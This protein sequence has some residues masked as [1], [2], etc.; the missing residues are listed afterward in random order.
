DTTTRLWVGGDGS[1]RIYRK[2][3]DSVYVATRIL[4]RSDSIAWSP[5]AGRYIRWGANKLQVRFDTTGMHRETINR[6]GHT[7]IFAGSISQLDSIGVPTATSAKLWYHFTYTDGKL[8]RISAPGADSARNL[9]ISQVDGNLTDIAG[10]DTTHVHFT[11]DDGTGW[12]TAR[13]DRSGNTAR[14]GY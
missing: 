5:G 10:P 9:V 14:Y 1:A 12:M 3:H 8:T 4:N 7:T 6:L 11:Y 13:Q 2:A